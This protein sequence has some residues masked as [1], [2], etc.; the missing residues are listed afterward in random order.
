MRVADVMTEASI[1]ESAADTLRAAA[2]LMWHEQT[3]SVVVLDG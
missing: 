3:G 1:S 2:E